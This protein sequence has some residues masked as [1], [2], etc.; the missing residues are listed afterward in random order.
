MRKLIII[1][2]TV[3]IT[4][5]AHSQPI[6]AFMLKS[7]N[8]EQVRY[9]DYIIL[10]GESFLAHRIP[11]DSLRPAY[12]TRFSNVK[13]FNS[14]HP[15]SFYIPL[16]DVVWGATAAY[17]YDTYLMRMIAD[18]LNITARFVKTANGGT[19]LAFDSITAYN[20]LDK[21]PDGSFNVNVYGSWWSRLQGYINNVKTIE[22]MR[23]NVARFRLLIVDIH[24]NDS[25]YGYTNEY[26]NVVDGITSGS[27]LDFTRKIRQIT[28]NRNM[29]IIQYQTL[30]NY[31]TYG[32][33]RFLMKQRQDSIMKYIPN[34]YMLRMDDCQSCYPVLDGTHHNDVG[35]YNKADST[36]RIIKK[37]NLLGGW[38]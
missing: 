33:E 3:L 16:T 11:A 13:Y 27:F 10:Y 14:I 36:W 5:S 8:I 6:T 21:H 12:N 22:R 37:Y 15:D 25:W 24:A 31:A 35:D 34:M 4:I 17:S 30:T 32:A 18:S 9:V 26:F 19:C 28:G 7:N 23:G 38:Q 2:S 29:P 20:S 1:I